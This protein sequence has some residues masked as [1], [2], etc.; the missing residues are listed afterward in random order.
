V[1]VDD[2]VYTFEKGET[3]FME[4]SQKYTVEQ[5][6]ELAINTGF[7]SIKH[8]FDSKKWFLDAVWQCT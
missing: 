3:I 8:F 7:K 5:T 4:I 6:D 2:R 1:H